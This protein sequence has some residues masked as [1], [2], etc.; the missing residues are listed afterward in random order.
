MT[1]GFAAAAWTETDERMVAVAADTR[2]TFTD[3]RSDAGAK[4]YELGGPC[5]MVASGNALPP[6]MAAELTRSLIE[7]HNRRTPERKVS[8]FDTVR[9]ASFFLRRAWDEHGP[10]CRVAVAGFLEA[11]PPCIAS[12]VVSTGFNRTAFHRIAKGG[13]TAMPMGD[14]IAGRLLVESMAEAKKQKRP[15]IATAIN[16]LLY[17]AR[18]DGAF[19]TVGGGLSVGTCMFG[20]DYFSWPLIEIDGVRFLRGMDVTAAYRPGWPRP[21]VI[22]YD[23]AWCAEQD[24]RVASLPEKPLPK[25]GTLPG[26]DIDALKPETLFASHVEPDLSVQLEQGGTCDAD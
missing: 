22:P 13:T 9:L 8:F 4:T 11:G 19:P 10:P 7:N 6:M 15:T 5:A 20:A 26:F 18:H 1:L 12:I 16:V 25:G 2:I 23:E 3:G 17:T 14:P 21:E 24:Q